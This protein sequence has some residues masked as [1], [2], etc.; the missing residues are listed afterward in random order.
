MTD[1]NELQKLIERYDAIADRAYYNYQETGTARY[2]RE[3]RKAQTLADALRV[4]LNAAD[5]HRELVNLRVML[6]D[7]AGKAQ[8]ARSSEDDEAKDSALREVVAA[9]KLCDLYAE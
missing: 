9:A 1:K 2:D 7:L 6:S 4:A 3:Y 5:D 8:K